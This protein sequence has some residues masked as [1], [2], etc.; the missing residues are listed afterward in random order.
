MNQS[1]KPEVD[2]LVVDLDNTLWDWFDVWFK[3]FSALLDALGETTG[4]SRE[5]LERN[6]R[7]IHQ[8]RFTSEYSWL[9]DELSILD[10]FVGKNQ[11]TRERFDDAIHRQN[12]VRKH[13]TKLYP[14]VMETLRKVRDAGVPIVAYTES[15]AYWTEWRIKTVGLDG[16]IDR[17]YSS[18]DHDEPL[19]STV[20]QL[21]TL[22]PADYG[23]KHTEHH[24]VPPGVVKPDVNI[25]HQIVNE[26]G[27]DR[28]R[29]AYVGDS[30]MKD[31]AMA[32]AEGVI[33]VHAEYGDSH[34]DPRYAQL[35]RV[36]HWPDAAVTK[37]QSREPGAHPIATYTLDRDFGQLLEFF[38]FGGR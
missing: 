17:L 6:I 32:Q 23:L 27:V 3:S 12:S 22:P 8:A 35:Q 16:V 18:P 21:R 2:L 11:S 13:E 25:L 5:E 37:E 20:E 10:Q 30:L 38:A 33:D 36:S 4:L 26:Y 24:H 19:G 31:V 34:T 29:V 15:L 28:A 1:S 9:V 7:P 14:T